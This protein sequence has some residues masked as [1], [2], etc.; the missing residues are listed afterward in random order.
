MRD[1]NV[2]A[3]DRLSSALMPSGLRDLRRGRRFGCGR[4]GHA[5]DEDRGG[6]NAAD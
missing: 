6:G 2:C 1:L 3:R 5:A 4:D